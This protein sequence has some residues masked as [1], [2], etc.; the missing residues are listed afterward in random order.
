MYKYCKIDTPNQAVAW[1]EY[2]RVIYR[3]CW[4][5]RD[6]PQAPPRIAEAQ[7]LGKV[8]NGILKTL[9]PSNAALTTPVIDKDLPLLQQVA[10]AMKLVRTQ[11]PK[12]DPFKTNG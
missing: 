9:D 1:L 10:E 4:S 12:Q 11:Y 8:V 2:Y 6:Y 7:D 5:L 3:Y